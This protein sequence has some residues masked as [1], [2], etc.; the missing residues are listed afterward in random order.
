M[1]EAVGDHV[2]IPVMYREGAL[3]KPSIYRKTSPNLKRNYVKVQTTFETTCMSVVKGHF[4]TF[5]L[6]SA[7]F[8]LAEALRCLFV[9]FLY[10]LV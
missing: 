9:Q 4:F 6:P 8:C 5:S 2:K 1:E 7:E 3:S 10:F